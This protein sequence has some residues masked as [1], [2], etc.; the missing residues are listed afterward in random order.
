MTEEEFQW[1]QQNQ[2]PPPPLPT[3]ALLPT[4]IFTPPQQEPAFLKWPEGY[5]A[6]TTKVTALTFTH[7]R[8]H[9]VG[10]E[11]FFMCVEP[12][13]FPLNNGEL[14]QA[15]ITQLPSVGVWTMSKEEIA[16]L[17]SIIYDLACAKQLYGQ[18]CYFQYQGLDYQQHFKVERF[19]KFYNS[20]G[21]RVS[22]KSRSICK[23]TIQDV[24]AN[25]A[26]KISG[27]SQNL[28]TNVIEP[29][30][31][32]HT[33]QVKKKAPKTSRL[34]KMEKLSSSSPASRPTTTTSSPTRRKRVSVY[35]PPKTSAT[36]SNDDF[37]MY[38]T[39][40]KSSYC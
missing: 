39:P 31:A 13:I 14:V 25:I 24:E 18:V 30:I 20:G 3:K 12:I 1:L 38:S 21:H 5:I 19:S 6:G 16:R 26:L 34:L 15:Y 27:I 37:V 23:K 36:V 29:V 7:M 28:L 10:D 17:N 33:M 40:L 35:S 11:K 32:I 2:P 4:P 9:I 8:P 22:W